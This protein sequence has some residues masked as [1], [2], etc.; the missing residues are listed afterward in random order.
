MVTA[1]LDNLFYGG[2]LAITNSARI[3]QQRCL[4]YPVSRQQMTDHHLHVLTQQEVRT[5]GAGDLHQTSRQ[6]SDFTTCFQTIKSVH[7]MT[8]LVVSVE[9]VWV[10]IA[11]PTGTNLAPEHHVLVLGLCVIHQS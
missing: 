2:K 10:K 3:P 11:T 4:L 1:V 9:L 8:P 6:S 7:I 5:Y